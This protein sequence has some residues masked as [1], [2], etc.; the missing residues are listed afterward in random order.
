[1]RMPD[2]PSRAERLASAVAANKPE[3]VPLLALDLCRKFAAPGR[4]SDSR[5]VSAL[6]RRRQDDDIG[7]GGFRAARLVHAT[8]DSAS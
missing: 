8:Q 4:R 5:A 6:R 1:M 7:E 2:A 3:N